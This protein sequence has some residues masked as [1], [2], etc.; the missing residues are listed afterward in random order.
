MD[1]KLEELRKDLKVLTMI[2]DSEQTRLGLLQS[3]EQALVND[4]EILDA[5]IKEVKE[6]D[7]R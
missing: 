4:I 6:N 1:K 2:M 3:M 5:L 7:R